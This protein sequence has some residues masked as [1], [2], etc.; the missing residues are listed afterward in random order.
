MLKRSADEGFRPHSVLIRIWE[1]IQLAKLTPS[2]IQSLKE[3]GMACELD[4]ISYEVAKLPSAL[5]MPRETFDKYLR[6][7]QCQIQA[8]T[9]ADK[10]SDILDPILL[11]KQRWQRFAF[12]STRDGAKLAA[13]V[14]EIVPRGQ[15]GSKGQGAAQRGEQSYR[16]A[17]VQPPDRT[18]V[19][20]RLEGNGRLTNV[21]PND[22][23]RIQ[24]PPRQVRPSW[25]SDPKY[26]RSH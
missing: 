20:A 9:I 11:K 19:M 5:M 15:A 4:R 17:N 12:P 6:N 16:I 7:E 10:N 26:P 18:Y 2:P 1:A 8:D 24:E 22:Q 21:A 23:H 14:G 3:I 13:L 25:K